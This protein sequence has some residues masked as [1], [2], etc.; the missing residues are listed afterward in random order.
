MRSFPL[1][2]R[3][4][5]SKVIEKAGLPFL[6]IAAAG[7]KAIFIFTGAIPFNADE[8]IVGLM[9]RH[10]LQGERPVFFYGQVYM[11]SLDAYLIAGLFSIVGQK[12]WVIRIVQL[13]LYIAV[14]YCVYHIS[15]LVFNSKKHAILAALFMA[16]PAVNTTLYTTASLGGYG[17]AMLA[18]CI[19]LWAA[20]RCIVDDSLKPVFRGILFVVAGFS[21]GLGFWANALTLV[22]AAPGL[23]TLFLKRFIG[24]DRWMPVESVKLASL[25]IIGFVIG[26]APWWIYVLENGWQQVFAEFFGSAVSVEKTSWL[27]RSVDHMISLVVLGIPVVVGLRP[28]WEI[29]WLV[30]PVGV[31]VLIFWTLAATN[32]IMKCHRPSMIRWAYKLLVGMGGL[33]AAGFVFTSF[34][35]DP[36]GRYFLPLSIPMAILG[37]DF[38]LTKINH[39]QL[40]YISVALVILYHLWGTVDCALRIPPGIS[41]Q[42]N[43]V[44]VIDDRDF[45]VMMKFLKENGET[46]G[47]SNY[48][49]AYPLAFLSNEEMIFS[50]RLPYHSDLRY[51]RRD[52]RYRSYTR[53]VEGSP[54]VAYITTKNPSLDE[55]LTTHFFN[56]GVTWKEKWIG[57]FHIFY[58]LSQSV[59]PSQIGLDSPQS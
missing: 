10:I 58:N 35:I 53:D 45:P 2:L 44:T 27:V 6:L 5:L 48:W 17:E 36:S 11:G 31:L 20:I 34:G 57:D 7:W 4:K 40:R 56:A 9:A 21:L 55:T 22:I 14:I 19:V 50:P 1:I 46:R 41:T 3:D 54:R 28:P 38:V 32:S 29:R 13:I 15:L 30:L 52:D 47:Y 37:A 12:V 59:R 43:P 23:V 24:K 16:F 25:F 8:A 26:A 51:T 42:F 49:V 39:R 18:G 33:L